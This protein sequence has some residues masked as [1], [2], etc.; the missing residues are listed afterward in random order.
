MERR[1]KTGNSLNKRFLPPTALE[2]IRRQRSLHFEMALRLGA[3][4]AVAPI[5]ENKDVGGGTSSLIAL[6]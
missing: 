6:A 2:S 3:A 5:K 4:K 1:Q